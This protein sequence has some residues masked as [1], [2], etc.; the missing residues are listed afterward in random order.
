[1]TDAEKIE[2]LTQIRNNTP[3]RTSGEQAEIDREVAEID[4]LI[5]DYNE[6][7]AALEEKLSDPN[8]Y[9]YT[10]AFVEER[11]MTFELLEDSF[12]EQLQTI[13]RENR[14]HAE[15]L[16]LTSRIMRSYDEEIATLNGDISVLER[17]LRKNDVAV[18][19]N[20]RMQLSQE[21]LFNLTTE[22]ENKKARLA[23]CKKFS[24][25]YAEEYAIASNEYQDL[26]VANNQRRQAII[27]KQDKLEIVKQAGIIKASEI[28]KYKMRLDQDQLSR[29]R[30]GVVA[31]QSRKE[32]I[33]YDAFDKIN[34]LIAD[35][36][37]K[38]QKD[39]SNTIVAGLENSE[40]ISTEGD[41]MIEPEV[42][43][44]K[45]E[46]VVPVL[47]NPENTT[48]DGEEIN[49]PE[50]EETK[51]TPIVA[52]IIPPSSEDPY[53]LDENEPDYT[54]SFTTGDDEREAEIEDTKEELLEK[55]KWPKVKAFLKK[56]KGK[57]IAAG[58]ALVVLLAAKGC[59]QTTDLDQPDLNNDTS[60]TQGYESEEDKFDENENIEE[61]KKDDQSNEMGD[62]EAVDTEKDDEIKTEPD[63]VPE[64]NP[65]LEPEIEIE[66]QPEI[67]PEP[68]LE[69]QPE[70]TPE[71]ELNKTVELEA[72]ESV[73]DI[74]DILQGNRV[75]HG[76]E[77]GTRLDSGIEV[78][79]Y[80]EEGNAIVELPTESKTAVL[81][82]TENK[83][84]HEMLEEFFGGPISI[85]DS[86]NSYETGEEITSGKT[87]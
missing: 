65:E 14:E 17:R 76:D 64:T 2:L 71:P 79:E 86:E 62:K 49:E 73:A 85:T 47:E 58:L 61:D 1:M 3:V 69:I 83:D 21:E 60:Y 45:D 50:V 18:S 78:N 27:S 53:S 33:S 77:I 43:E 57:F 48:T 5:E 56:H 59:S 41:E 55:K 54:S 30:A 37:K 67:T 84:F 4:A 31:L 38:S 11:E 36:E 15:L 10:S 68:D 24:E 7:I 35:L 44:T 87:R 52:P 28:D 72:G 13:E 6:Q 9:K 80:T 66:T 26:I 16:D 19:R 81:D 39:N 25:Q 63:P 34:L 82:E 12:E 70:I 8:N 32:S 40:N 74:S 20:M 46:L 29:L 42:E 51:D 23:E 75:E 22:L